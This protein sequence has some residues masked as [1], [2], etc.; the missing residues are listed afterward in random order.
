MHEF[1]AGLSVSVLSGSLSHIGDSL[2][3]WVAVAF[4][5]SYVRAKGREGD[6][7][8]LDPFTADA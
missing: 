6:V 4:W 5:L 1:R 8:Q 7:L 2:T 3:F